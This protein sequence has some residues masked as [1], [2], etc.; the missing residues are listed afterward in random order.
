MKVVMADATLLAMCDPGDKQMF[1][2]K[3][4]VFGGFEVLVVL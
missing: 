3:R 4:M 1:D 2:Y